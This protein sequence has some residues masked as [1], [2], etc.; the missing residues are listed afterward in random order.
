MPTFPIS[1]PRLLLLGLLAAWHAPLPAAPAPVTEIRIAVPDLGAGSRPS[2]G[3]LVDVLR[4]QQLFEQAFAG[5]GIHIAWTFFKGAGPAV[6][7]ALASGQVD[8]AF[9]GDLAAIIGKAGGLDTRLLCATARGIKSYLGVVPGSGI[10]TLLDLKGRRVALFRGTANQ[11]S[12]DAALASQGL[13]ERDIKVI[14]LD[15]NASTAALA[16]RQVDAVWGLSNLI[17]LRERGLAQIPLSSRDIQG[18]GSTQAVL[19]GA[20]AFVDQHPELVVRLLRAHQQAVRWLADEANREAYLDLVSAT[21]GYP[22]V[23]LETDLEGERLGEMFAPQLDPPFLD[24]LQ[25]GVEFALAQRLIRKGF[26]V[27]EW[28]A[29]R[30]LEAALDASL[31]GAR[32]IT[33]GAKA[34]PAQAAH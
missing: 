25:A 4:E 2:G 32:P 18:A 16:A 13:S 21:A 8:F 5:D 15:F 10:K 30:F 6:N 9:L 29:P 33:D 17:A 23:I 24:H 19:V 1:W 14:N 27:R 26:Q 31:P 11:L 20:G 7:E 34:P 22:R 12:F 3:G 28:A